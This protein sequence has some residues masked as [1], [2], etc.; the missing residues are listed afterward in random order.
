VQ[1]SE[2]RIPGVRALSAAGSAPVRLGCG[3][4]PTITVNGAPVLTRAAG[5]VTDLL[6]GRP[7]AFS[8]C[9]GVRIAAGHNSVVEPGSDP[10]GF[11]LQSVLVDPAGAAGLRADPAVPSSPARSISW[12]SSS[13]VLRVAA[14][15]RSFLIVRENFN[16]GWQAT[17][18]GQVLEPVQLDGWE[19]AWLLPAGTRGLVQ[20]SYLPDRAYRAALGGGLGALALVLLAAFVPLRRRRRGAGGAAAG[21]GGAESRGPGSGP[22]T[23]SDGAA[24]PVRP[25]AGLHRIARLAG[26][27]AGIVAL[28]GAG[29]WLGGYPAALLLPVVTVAAVLAGGREPAGRRWRRVSRERLAPALLLAAAAGGAASVLLQDRGDHGAL[30]TGL[31]NAGPQLACLVIVGVLV[32]EVVRTDRAGPGTAAAPG[33]QPRD[34]WRPPTPPSR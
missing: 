33:A 26:W 17:I 24:V 20:L 11:D 10:R 18:G 3:Q 5:T 6:T 34:S 30:L 22:E 14:T 15:S 25:A 12:T 32:A 2:V 29:L 23:E 13:R 7:L 27:L 4:G 1:V 28:A 9:S 31:G 19:Q 21:T 8:A 16:R